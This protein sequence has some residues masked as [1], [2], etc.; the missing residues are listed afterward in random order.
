MAYEVDPKLLAS[1][2]AI[3]NDIEADV[4][5]LHEGRKSWNKQCGQWLVYSY[6][7]A[8]GFGGSVQLES[9]VE[10]AWK[11]KTSISSAVIK[12]FVDISLAKAIAERGSK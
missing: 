6:E 3:A 4:L 12:V 8:L 11:N 5:R 1:V 2:V 7:R 9:A 10:R